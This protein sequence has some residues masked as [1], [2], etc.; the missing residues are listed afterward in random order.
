MPL[1][2]MAI[3]DFHNFL[4]LSEKLIFTFAIY[5]NPG[6]AIHLLKLL[7]ILLTVS[8]CQFSPCHVCLT[9]FRYSFLIMF[10]IIFSCHFLVLITIFHFLPIFLTASMLFSASFCRTTSVASSLLF[11]P[12]ENIQH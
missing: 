7:G 1:Q 12:G 8:F 9:F 10:P 5:T 6:P 2:C 11:I 4:H 3:V